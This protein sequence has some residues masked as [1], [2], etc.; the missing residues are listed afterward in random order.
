MNL[1]GDFERMI[2]KAT[3]GLGFTIWATKSYINDFR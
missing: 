2:N 3:A 1:N